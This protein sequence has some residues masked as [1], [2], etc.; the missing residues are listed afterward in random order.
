MCKPCR[1]VTTISGRALK[2]T[3]RSSGGGP[4]KRSA[5]KIQTELWPFDELPKPIMVSTTSQARCL[6]E[7][8]SVSARRGGQSSWGTARRR[9]AF[10]YYF[11]ATLQLCAFLF[12]SGLPLLPGASKLSWK[13]SRS[14]PAK[15]AAIR[16]AEDGSHRAS[17]G[18]PARTIGACAV[19]R[20][21]TEK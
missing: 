4:N 19:L 18:Q 1:L 7:R 5:Y 17:S 15:R 21:R 3:P 13:T 8:Q 2:T 10:L 16:R 12:P 9:P 11:G 6:V 20:R 14:N